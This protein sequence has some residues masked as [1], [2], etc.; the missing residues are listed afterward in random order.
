MFAKAREVGV[1]DYNVNVGNREAA[2][3]MD[4]L[5]YFAGMSQAPSWSYSGANCSSTHFSVGKAD[6]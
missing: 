2:A 5:A 3:V 4:K 6:E 1:A